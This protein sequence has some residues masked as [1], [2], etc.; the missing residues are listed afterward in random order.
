MLLRG[1]GASSFPGLPQ[2]WL[3]TT[4][5]FFRVAP[6]SRSQHTLLYSTARI[7]GFRKV[8]LH[9]QVTWLGRGEGV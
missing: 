2:C 9:S 3:T 6:G 4:W 7:V 5:W 1:D 8:K